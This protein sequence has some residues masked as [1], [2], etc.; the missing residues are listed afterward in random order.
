MQ[1]PGTTNFLSS[2]RLHLTQK[3]T[4]SLGCTRRYRRLRRYICRTKTQ[5]SRTCSP[6]LASPQALPVRAATT[7]TPT[8]SSYSCQ[9]CQTPSKTGTWG[10]AFSKRALPGSWGGM[11]VAEKVA[12]RHGFAH[13]LCKLCKAR[14]WKWDPS[15]ELRE[16]NNLIKTDKNNVHAQPVLQVVFRAGELKSLIKGLQFFSAPREDIS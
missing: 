14:L 11:G 7:L 16:E 1:K 10:S 6:A 15:S 2:R 5:P 9:R 13:G 8:L 12:R 3:R 4:Q